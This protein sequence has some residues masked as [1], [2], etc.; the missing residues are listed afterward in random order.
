MAKAIGIDLGTYFSSVAYLTNGQPRIIPNAEGQSFTPSVVAFTESGLLLVGQAAKLQAAAN[1]RRT[2]FSIKRHM[3]SSYE[4]RIGNR[5]YRP[6]EIS[7]FILRK[8]KEDAELYLGEDIGK[9]VITVP[10]YF[11]DQQRQATKEAAALAGLDV[12]GLLSEPTAAALAYGIHREEANTILVWDLGAGTFDVSILELGE[13]IFEVQAVSGDTRLGGDDFTQRVA[14]YLALC[15]QKTHGTPLP[16]DPKIRQRVHEAAERAKISLCYSPAARVSLPF[17]AWDSYGSRHLE[18]E[19]TREEFEGLTSGLLG[20]LVA[21]TLQALRDGSLTPEQI[22]RVILVGGGCL[23]SSVRRLATQILGKEPYRYIDP[24]TVVARGAAIYSGMLLGLVEE[25]VLLDVLPLSLGVE[26]QGNLMAKLIHGNTPLPASGDRIFTT[27]QDYQT[28]IDIHVIQGERELAGDN[29]S[30]GH[31]EL[32]G[33]P[34]AQKGLPKI[35]VALE[36]DVDGM[37]HVSAKEL[38]TEHEMK[39][40]VPSTKMLDPQ[41]I[42]KLK[43][44]SQRN[45]EQDKEKRIRILAGIEANNTIEAAEDAMEEARHSLSDSQLERLVKGIRDVKEA[46]ASGV[47]DEIRRRCAELRRLLSGIS[48]GVARRDVGKEEPLNSETISRDLAQTMKSVGQV[49]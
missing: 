11:N 34:S 23:M 29:I 36:T 19:L 37:V 21:P 43:E 9:A 38:L 6:Q 46:L 10:A 31:F 5:N 14:E 33:I 26:T 45:E 48:Q 40:K 4:V 20:R 1:P 17:L 16:D 3:G 41:E 15:F 28:S 22:D 42:E 49:Y 8:L 30:L 25:V 2:V 35:E 13:G 39:V 47:V 27:A 12:L 7:S 24:F 32:Q 18:S 44:E